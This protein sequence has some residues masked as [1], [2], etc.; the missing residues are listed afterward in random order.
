MGW[1]YMNRHHM[2]GHKTPKA[3]L[4]AEFTFT[5]APGTDGIARGARVLASSCPGNRVWYAAVQYYADGVPGE[6]IAM[7]CLVRW[8][9]RDKDDLHFGYKDMSEGMGPCE[10]ACPAHILDLLTPTDNEYARD[11]RRRCRDRLRLRSRKVEDGMRIRLAEPLT[12]TDG[13][14]GAE[15]IV[16]KRGRSLSFR[17]P[18]GYGRYRISHFLDREWSIVP[19][20]RVYPAIFASTPSSAGANP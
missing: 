14:E 12:F 9:P 17:P 18:E 3:Y 13:H 8:N 19:R 20:T 2:G 4:D 11:W 10:A 6:V 1:L 15:F 7:V 5:N 16:V